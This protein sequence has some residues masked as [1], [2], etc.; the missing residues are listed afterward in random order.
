M[1]STYKT[2]GVYIE[3]ISKL[4]PS[5]AQVETAIPAFIGYTEKAEKENDPEALLGIPTRIKSLEEYREKFG[6]APKPVSLE[7][8]GS[9]EDD[10][11]VPKAVDIQ[12]DYKLYNSLELFFANGGGP[13]YIVSVGLY[14]TPVSISKATLETGVNALKKYD[15]PT[16]IVVPDAVS[17]DLG[18]DHGALMADALAQCNDL[19]DRFTIMD[20][21]QGDETSVKSS[22]S[23][24]IADNFRGAV[25]SPYLKYG[26]SYFPFLKAFLTVNFDH[27]DIT[28]KNG[29]AVIADLADLDD[30]TASGSDFD[31]VITALT[32]AKAQRTAVN[33]A[34]KVATF[35]NAYAVAVATENAKTRL[36]NMGK[37]IKDTSA[38]LVGLL[39][40]DAATEIP[41]T[42]SLFDTIAGYTNAGNELELII[43]KLLEYDVTYPTAGG[44]TLFNVIDDDE[45]VAV[46]P[47]AEDTKPGGFSA[48][49]NSY[50]WE[51]DFNGTDYTGAPNY[52]L[53]QINVDTLTGDIYTGATNDSG[54]YTKAKPYFD[55]L[56][57]R[58]V[59]LLEVVEAAAQE[60]VSDEEGVLKGTTVYQSVLQ[61]INNTPLEMPP[62]G[63][64]TGIYARV[65]NN[66]GVWKAPANVVVSS[67]LGPSVK[68]DDCDQESLNV[69]PTSGK[70]VNAIRAFTGKGT[71]VW[72]ARTLAGN[73]NE[74]R[75]VSVRRFFNMV[76]ESIKKATGWAVFEPNDAN[77]WVKLKA[78]IENYLTTLWRQG[79]LAGSA[80]DQAFFVKVG[81]DETMTS[82]DILEGRL[83]I[84][85]GMAAV[86]PAEFI[87]LKFSHKMQ[88]A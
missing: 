41:N 45:G 48:P 5:V 21:Y 4:P 7:V 32:T 1:A 3:E 14:A 26:A 13:C 25:S 73:D 86:R 76:E 29:D 72:G 67:I 39:D 37:A 9:I 22:G 17:L 88:E 68:V 70:S 47:P 44:L 42:I 84:E 80:P 18:S 23:L 46:D 20:V 33:G 60:S 78:M 85:I 75:Y 35:K 11:F 51:T 49:A 15:E 24:T 34:G 58:M 61:K 54:R 57:E 87:I 69:D 71:L 12:V 36:K 55:A 50:V 27:E 30:S 28:F 66:R 2:P 82:V 64:V 38:A 81:L 53:Y 56:Y 52:K 59:A 6:S 62:C 31:A 10:V 43:E 63:A 83:N 16:L 65:D 40:P 8:S 74:W 79:A 19:K 77:L